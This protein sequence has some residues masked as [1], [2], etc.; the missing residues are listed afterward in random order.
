MIETQR[1]GPFDNLGTRRLN[2]IINHEL[3]MISN[4]SN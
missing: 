3:T 4:V 2:Q 1:G